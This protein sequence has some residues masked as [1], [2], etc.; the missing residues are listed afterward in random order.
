V[1]S[2]QLE[3]AIPKAEAEA[4]D[5]AATIEEAPSE[6]RGQTQSYALVDTP[7]EDGAEVFSLIRDSY[8]GAC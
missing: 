5:Y 6:Y 4:H 1:A 2:H 8:L 3:K 7:T